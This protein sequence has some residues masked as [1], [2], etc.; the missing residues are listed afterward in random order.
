MSAPT[1]ASA[2]E[3]NVYTGDDGATVV[4]IHTEPYAGRLRV[5]VNDGPVYDAI[6]FEARPD[7]AHRAPAPGSFTRA[8]RDALATYADD[9]AA[10][11]AEDGRG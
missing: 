10:A 7:E 8:V 5:N 4:H 3:I 1:S 2:P 11:L 9:L 6:V